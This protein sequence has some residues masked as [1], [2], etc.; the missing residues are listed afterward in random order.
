VDDATAT[1]SVMKGAVAGAAGPC[2]PGDSKLTA[3][4][5]AIAHRF[6]LDEVSEADID[7]C[8]VDKA[9]EMVAEVT[10][11]EARVPA[12]AEH[13][14]AA[15]A[16]KQY[17][18]ALEDVQKPEGWGFRDD[19][20]DFS[21]GCLEKTEIERELM[22]AT[23]PERYA[24]EDIQKPEGWGF[25]EGHDLGVH[26]EGGDLGMRGDNWLQWEDS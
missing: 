16:P 23:A 3:T 8:P 24:L 2:S 15:T 13:A 25:L 11:A 4:P 19:S 22:D 10:E 20:P 18:Y 21:N 5:P 9:I 12:E 17:S 26:P 1:A 14:E 6:E 7:L